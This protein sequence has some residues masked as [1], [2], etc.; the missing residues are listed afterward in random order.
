MISSSTQK[1]NKRWFVLHAT[2]IDGVVRMEYF[3]HED[4]EV[5]EIGKRT[6]PLRDC[7]NASQRAGTKI[8]PYVFEFSTQLGEQEVQLNL[9]LE[10]SFIII[11][12]ID[13]QP[14]LQGKGLGI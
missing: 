14:T 1:W 6:V 9:V 13:S 5:T 10:I 11:I 3:D 2:S 8:R 4:C 12:Y 7:A